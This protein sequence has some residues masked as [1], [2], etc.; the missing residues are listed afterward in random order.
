[1]KL[2]KDVSLVVRLPAA[3]RKNFIEMCETRDT[4]ASREVRN[5]I[6]EYVLKNQPELGLEIKRGKK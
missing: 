5:F 6:R 4:T 3:L 2:E 1:M